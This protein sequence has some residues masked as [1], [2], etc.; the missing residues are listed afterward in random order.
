MEWVPPNILELL[1]L[2][3][4]KLCNVSINTF[5]MGCNPFANDLFSLCI[6]GKKDSVQFVIS[7]QIL[8]IV[9]FFFFLNLSTTFEY[10]TVFLSNN[11]TNISFGFYKDHFSLKNPLFFFFK[12]RKWLKSNWF[13]SFQYDIRIWELCGLTT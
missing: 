7:K 12:V 13:V 1:L 4:T 3:L 9:I 5:R 8:E 6:T 2:I 10:F 11:P